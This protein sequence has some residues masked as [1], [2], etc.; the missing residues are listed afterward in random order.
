MK[1]KTLAAGEN[2]QHYYF[3]FFLFLFSFLASH[4][5]LFVSGF[6]M[7]HLLCTQRC[8]AG[9]ALFPAL[10]SGDSALRIF[11]SSIPSLSTQ[12]CFQSLSQLTQRYAFHPIYTPLLNSA[13]ESAL[14]QH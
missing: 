11:T 8:S 12:R 14:D 6:F 9:S 10:T 7:G 1:K 13:L 4:F 2:S 3:I 5:L